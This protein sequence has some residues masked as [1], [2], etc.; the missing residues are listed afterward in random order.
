MNKRYS[1]FKEIDNDLRILRLQR[2]IDREALKLNYQEVRSSFYPTQLL[3]GISGIVQKIALTVVA[4]K[5][6]RIFR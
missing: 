4:K 6:L 1:T 2:E 5:I 3:G